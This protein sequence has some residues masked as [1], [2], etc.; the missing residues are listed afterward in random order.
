MSFAVTFILVW[1]FLLTLASLV[2][3]LITGKPNRILFWLLFSWWWPWKRT[4]AATLLAK[5]IEGDTWNDWKTS[6]YD[7][8][9]IENVKLSAVVDKWPGE[10]RVKIN[11]ERIP[12]SVWDNYVL[13]SAFRKHRNGSVSTRSSKIDEAVAEAIIRAYGGG[14]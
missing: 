7:S 4:S 1:V 6:S 5:T 9:K 3:W 14:K 12:I 8:D 11:G 2:G 13:G 10:F